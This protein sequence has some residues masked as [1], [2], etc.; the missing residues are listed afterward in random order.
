MGLFYTLPVNFTSLSITEEIVKP[1]ISWETC[2]AGW[3]SL[4]TLDVMFGL[5]FHCHVVNV[6]ITDKSTIR[7]IMYLHILGENEILSYHA[8]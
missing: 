6:G 2:N 8:C 7:D 4:N 1:A 5:G 3:G